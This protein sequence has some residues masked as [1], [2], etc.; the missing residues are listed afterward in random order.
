M[1]LLARDPC[2]M[3]GVCGGALLGGRQLIC[4]YFIAPTSASTC[5][6]DA[7]LVHQTAVEPYY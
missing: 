1:A 4:T 3:S 2:N 6:Q 7:D 5:S